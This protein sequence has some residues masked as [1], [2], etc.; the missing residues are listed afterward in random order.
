MTI[1]SQISKSIEFYNE[2]VKYEK[3]KNFK[4]A[5]KYYLN[6]IKINPNFFQAHYNLANIKKILMN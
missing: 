4:L 5:E 2:G 6:A 3:N 1:K